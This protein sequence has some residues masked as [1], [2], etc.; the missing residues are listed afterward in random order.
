MCSEQKPA[1]ALTIVKKCKSSYVEIKITN[2]CTFSEDSN[3][4]LLISTWVSIVLSDNLEYLVIW[5]LS[6]PVGA[7]LKELYCIMTNG[8]VSGGDDCCNI[9]CST[10]DC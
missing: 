1:T 7:R 8:A 9:F 5:H 3:K 4:K 2:K 10:T 6:G